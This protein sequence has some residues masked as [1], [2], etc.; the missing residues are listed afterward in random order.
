MY[1]GMFSMTW[2]VK[3]VIFSS[4]QGMKKRNPKS[5]ATILGTKLN[6]ISWMA[7]TA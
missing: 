7:V 6:V 3:V 4:I 5:T 2:V 1:M